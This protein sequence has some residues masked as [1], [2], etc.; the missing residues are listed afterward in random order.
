[1]GLIKGYQESNHPLGDPPSCM[2]QVSWWMY[3]KHCIRKIHYQ[4]LDINSSIS[5]IREC[6]LQISS[7]IFQTFPRH[8]SDPISY[9]IQPVE[10]CGP[11]TLM[12]WSDFH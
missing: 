6:V 12:S 3:M 7:D 11:K 4:V 1:M 10:D 9:I 2:L 5:R 8:F